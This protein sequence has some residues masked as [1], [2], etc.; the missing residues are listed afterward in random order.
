MEKCTFCIQRIMEARENAI[1]E[2]RQLQG[3]DV[4]TA[5]QEACITNAISFGDVSDK[6]SEVS[7]FR[8]HGLSYHVLE[9][10]NVRPNVTYIAKLRNTHKESV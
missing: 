9:V 3:T 10:L 6:E 5:C 7:K 4:K 2:N 1:E 8:E